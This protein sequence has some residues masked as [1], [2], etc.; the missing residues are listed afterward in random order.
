MEKISQKELLN[1]GI[2]DKFKSTKLGGLA[3]GTLETAKQ[4]SKHIAPEVYN[5]IASAGDKI[6]QSIA[7]IRDKK[8]PWRDR[9][10]NWVIEQGRFPISEVKM[11]KKYGRD[12]SIHFAVDVAEKGVDRKTGEEVGGRMYTTP[13]AIVSYNPLKDQYKWVVR[14][15]FDSYKYTGHGLNKQF[16]YYDQRAK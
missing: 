14:P 6:R 1:E 13:H 3:S 8:M 9:I 11:L 7:S 10:K 12:G 16:I 15:R 2:W 5:P 4:I